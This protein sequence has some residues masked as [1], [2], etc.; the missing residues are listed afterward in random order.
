[1]Q[2][3]GQTAVYQLFKSRRKDT[4]LT[5][6]LIDQSGNIEE[7]LYISKQAGYSDVCFNNETNSAFVVFE[8]EKDIRIA[9]IGF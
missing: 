4:D 7:T 6:K 9:E 1:M 3:R 2:S 8:A 5:A